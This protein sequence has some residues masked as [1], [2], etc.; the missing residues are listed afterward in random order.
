MRGVSGGRGV[1]VDGVD[2]EPCAAVDAV[3]LRDRGGHGHLQRP[4]RVMGRDL[5]GGPGEDAVRVGR[6][7]DVD[8]DA[9]PQPVDVGH[10]AG[11][12]SA[13]SA[14][15]GAQGAGA[16]RVPG[17]PRISCRREQSR[18]AVGVGGS[19]RRGPVESVGGGLVRAP[20][21]RSLCHPVQRVSDGRIG[22]GRR[23]RTV[24]RLSVRVIAQGLRQ[25]RVRPASLQARR[26]LIDRRPDQRMPHR[27]PIIDDREQP[28]TLGLVPRGRVHAKGG[29]SLVHDAGPTG[30]VRGCHQ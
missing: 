4:D 20:P 18:R 17:R 12:S 26:G 14:G 22:S 7:P 11:V 16:C 2:G 19:Q 27:D 9:S 24:P 3:A 8:L 25:R 28:G 30:V 29:G 15:R 1:D 23:E 10:A 6:G 13:S 5:L 21:L